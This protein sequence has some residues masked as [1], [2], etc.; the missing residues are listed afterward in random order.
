M[1]YVEV[2]CKLYKTL[3]KCKPLLLGFWRIKIL[4]GQLYAPTVPSV[5]MLQGVKFAPI[6]RLQFSSNMFN[7]NVTLREASV[8][9]APGYSF[10]ST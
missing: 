7:I 4:A 9:L 5:K 6:T 1:I 10:A 8:L 3:Q 2:F